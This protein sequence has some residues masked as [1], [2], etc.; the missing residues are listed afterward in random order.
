MKNILILGSGAREKALYDILSS[1]NKLVYILKSKIFKNIKLYCIKYNI[2]LVI[3]S[4]EDYLCNGIV[5]YLENEFP[6]IM[7]FGPSKKNS[8]IESSKNYS[9]SLMIKLNIPTAK[10]KYFKSYKK[11]IKWDNLNKLNN[12]DNFSLTNLPVLKY[13]GLA[14]GKGVYLPDNNN[15]SESI[16]DIFK[17][18]NAG[19]LIEERL[20]GTEVSVLAFCNGKES[21]LMPQT[22]D[23]KRIYDNDKGPNT[24][25]MGAICPANV[26]NDN[27]L[28]QVKNHMDKIVTSLQYI[29]VLYAGIIKTPDGIYFLEFNCRLGDPETQVILNLLDSNLTNII[30]SCINKHDKENIDIKWKNKS[31]AVVILS[32]I[33]YPIKKL[34]TPIKIDYTDNIDSSIKIYESNVLNHSDGK[35]YTTG[36]RVL[37]MVSVDNTIYHALENIYNNIYKISFPGAYYRRDIGYSY[38]SNMINRINST[39][40]TTNIAI[41]ASGNG[42]CLEYLFK[43]NINSIKIIITNKSNAGINS[44]A[45]HN[46]IPFVYIPQGNCSNKEYYE[47]I[48]NILRLYNIEL[49][50][51]AGYMKIVPDTLFNE[52]FTINIHPS[53]LPKYSGLMDVNL[54]ERVIAN[55]ETFSGCTLHRVTEQVD[56]GRILLQKQYKLQETETVKSLRENIQELEKQCIIDYINLY[57]T[58]KCK[59]EYSVD[60]NQA[61]DF[62]NNIKNHISEIG[63]FC[64]EYLYKGLHIA[65]SADGC[66]TKLD[67]ANMHDRLNTIGIDLVA[68]NVNDL[69]AGGAKPLFFMDY[70]A[71]DK[72]NIKKCNDIIGG[73]I[74]GCKIADCKLI[75]GETSEMKGTYL[76]SKCD[77]AGFSIGEIQFDLPKKDKMFDGCILYG[78]ASSGI[79]SNGYTLVRKLLERANPDDNTRPKIEEILEPTV[80]YNTVPKLWE[81]FPDNILGISHI[82]GGGYH[83]NISRILPNDLYFKLNKWEFP[84]IFKWLQKESKLSDSEMLNTFNCGYGMVIIANKELNIENIDPDL[85]FKLEYIGNICKK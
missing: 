49:V 15:I 39:L 3:P 50:I 16:N 19:L 73:I 33:D 51:L 23:Y 44:K 17:L 52:F 18:G 10:Y 79:H 31:S 5:D 81:M 70:I 35:K 8:T 60:I 58:L 2:E 11:W 65:A 56:A 20:Y 34:N 7:V 9:K 41:L 12:A 6:N 78:I 55:K 21:L 72:M 25:G 27:E 29:G 69:I 32:H 22:Q 30:V 26:L 53:L 40:D 63:G 75:G 54:H 67:L 61:N 62:V 76:K 36:G 1:E 38:N 77:L 68:M 45:C 59:T 85:E 13:S 71:L 37:S 84:D 80:I 83:D 48:V 43:Y 57:N 64:A 66:G 82:T 24:G 28:L 14:N 42:T 47:K 4:S 46:K 74:E